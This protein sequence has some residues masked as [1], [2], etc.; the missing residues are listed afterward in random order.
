MRD[1]DLGGEEESKKKKKKDDFIGRVLASGA[2][3]GRREWKTSFSNFGL[4][5]AV[6][7]GFEK[8]LRSRF[9]GV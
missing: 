1:W 2:S 4:E 3:D 9:I 5:T 8:K 7:V 6:T